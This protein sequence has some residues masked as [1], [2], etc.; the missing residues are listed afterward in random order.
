MNIAYNGAKLQ[1]WLRTHQQRACNELE[2]RAP[3]GHDHEASEET[4]TE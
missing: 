4:C 3:V 2:L 1:D